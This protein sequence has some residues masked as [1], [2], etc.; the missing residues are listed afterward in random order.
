M[1]S[2]IIGLLGFGAVTLMVLVRIPVGISLGLVG[3]VGYIVISG[4]QHAFLKLG[5]MP[6]EIISYDLIVL[7]LFILMGA[8]C[9][10]S[11]MAQDIF[12][13]ADAVFAGRRGSLALAAVG[14]SA[15]FGSVS[16]SSLATVSTVAKVTAPEMKRAGYSLALAGGAIGSASTLAVLIPPSVILVIYAL[17][18]EESLGKLYAAALL[19][20][21]VLFLLYVFVVVIWVWVR[22]DAAPRGESMPLGRRLREM[23]R[24]WKI[25]LLFGGAIGGIYS[26]WFSP[27]EGAAVGAIIAIVIGFATRALSVRDLVAAGY[28]TVETTATLLFIVIG[29]TLFA[30]FIVQAGLPAAFVDTVRHYEMEPWQ[31]MVAIIVFYIIGGCFLDSIGMILMS[32]PVFLPVIVSLG[33]DPVWFGIL[34]VVLVEIGLITPPVG[35]NC[36]VLRSQIPEMKITTV[37]L[38]VTPF[39]AANIVMIGILLLYPDL[40]LM[41]PNALF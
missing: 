7:P 17:M 40:A 29:A 34:L 28:E 24:I 9:L 19:P 41:M 18:A 14:A 36:F 13:A 21:L 2:Q 38:G 8:V 30:Y 27:T 37:F 16:G 11:G 20:A 25:A 31:V 1:S 26:G 22:P 23:L 35:M 10:K 4:L 15:I 6:L 32:V 12:A 3:F 5:E 39:I 33:Y